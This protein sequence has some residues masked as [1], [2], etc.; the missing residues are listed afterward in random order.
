[1]LFAVQR[2]FARAVLGLA[3]LTWLT[4]AAAQTAGEWKYTIATDLANVP[5]DMRVNF[6]TVT[7]ATC[8]SADDFASGRAFA[9]Q[10]LASSSARCPSAG[11]VRAPL[12][13]GRGES[14]RFVYACDEGKTLSGSAQGRVFATAFSIELQS[15]YSPPVNGVAIIRQTMTGT[16]VGA[17]KV[18]PDADALKVE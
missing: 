5:A 11:Y 13:N 15:Q 6:P 14:L 16:R 12:P 1:M 2:R 10:T 17:C 8:R 9:L 18:Q 7:F 4:S 3:A